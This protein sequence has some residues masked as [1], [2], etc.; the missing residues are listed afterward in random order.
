MEVSLLDSDS[1]IS[2]DTISTKIMRSGMTLFF[3]FIFCF[4]DIN[5]QFVDGDVSH[6][7]AYYVNIYSISDRLFTIH[8]EYTYTKISLRVL[9][10]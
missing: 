4:V 1:S 9:S 7:T 8:L 6:V 10:T 2:Y 5:F 3:C